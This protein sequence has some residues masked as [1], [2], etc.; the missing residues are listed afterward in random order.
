MKNEKYVLLPFLITA[1]LL[2]NLLS[3][4]EETNETKNKEWIL[5]NGSE[6]Y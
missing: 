6:N 3:A 4:A 5:L 2:C 1:L